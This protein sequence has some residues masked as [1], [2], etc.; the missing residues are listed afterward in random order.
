MV[1]FPFFLSKLVRRYQINRMHYNPLLKVRIC[2]VL[3][4]YLDNIYVIYS[5][6][7]HLVVEPKYFTRF[8]VATGWCY[9]PFY[10]SRLQNFTLYTKRPIGHLHEFIVEGFDLPYSRHFYCVWINPSGADFFTCNQKLR[11]SEYRD[12]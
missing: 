5:Y 12:A 8:E 4:Y 6:S 7:N 9:P 2:F 3:C 11:E 10:C 1:L